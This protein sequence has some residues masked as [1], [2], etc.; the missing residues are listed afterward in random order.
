MKSIVCIEPGRLESRDVDKPARKS[1]EVLVKIKSIGICGTDIHAFGGNQPFF[2]YPRVLGHELA[3]I[4]EETCDNDNIPVGAFVYIIPYIS[5][6]ECIACKS[7]KPNCCE[8]IEVLGVHR[9]GGMTEYISVPQSAVVVAHGLHAHAVARAQLQARDTVLVQGSGPIGI[10]VAQFAKLSGA[11]VLI[12]DIH[13]GKLA[14]AVKNYAL[15]GSVD[16]K[17][18]VKQQLYDLT[19]GDMPTA[20]FD[21]TG[22]INAMQSAVT[23]LAH[24]GKIIY[25]SVVKD[26]LCFD[27]PEFHKREITMLGSRNATK[28]DFEEVVKRMREGSVTSSGFITDVVKFADLVPFF[29]QC[30]KP[31]S[32][33]VKAVIEMED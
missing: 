13:E 22:N 26:K 30:S 3:G 14:A 15:D 25:V 28:D 33:I 32:G 7:E 21:C 24:G 20:I 11:R 9:D 27:D 16:A 18:D 6:G 5:C 12:S 1:N 10:G 23:N 29:D 31:D 8:N 2:A 19:D 4:V 17:G